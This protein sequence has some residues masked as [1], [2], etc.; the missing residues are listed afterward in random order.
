VLVA[1]GQGKIVFQCNRCNPD[2]VLRNECPKLPQ[3]GVDPPI[4][5]S[6]SLAKSKNGAE[7]DEILNLRQALRCER[8]F[9]R[10]I[11]KLTQSGNWQV[12]RGC[13]P[14]PLD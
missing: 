14:K 10:S 7:L 4:V 5:V 8:R 3:L 2:I 1:G 12:E 13:L 9:V 11:E 6:C